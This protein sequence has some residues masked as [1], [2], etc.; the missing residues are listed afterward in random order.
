M[1]PLLDHLEQPAIHQSGEVRARGGSR[2]ARRVGEFA[3]RQCP[4]VGQRASIR[5]RA[6]SP[7]SAATAAIPPESMVMSHYAGPAAATASTDTSFR[8]KAS[9]REL[10]SSA[11]HIQA[12]L[13]QERCDGDPY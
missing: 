9:E 12:T 6:V 4:P 10:A 1:P 5:A 8:S 7:T 2:D 13:K 3:G 11:H